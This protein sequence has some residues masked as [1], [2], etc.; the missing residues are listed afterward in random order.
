M[1][2]LLFDA[3]YSNLDWDYCLGA[4]SE[5]EGGFSCWGSCCGPVGP[6]DIGQFLK[7]GFLSI[8]QLG[9]DDLE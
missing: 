4:V 3:A 5:S 1:E 7:L 2:H 8:V 9:F 6:Q